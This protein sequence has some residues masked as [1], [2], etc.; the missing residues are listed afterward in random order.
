MNILISCIDCFFDGRLHE[1][2]A[3]FDSKVVFSDD[4]SCR[5]CALL[6][7]QTERR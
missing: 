7:K 4:Y 5:R 1:G 6:A 3:S 2:W